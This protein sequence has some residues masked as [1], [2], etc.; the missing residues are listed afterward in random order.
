MSEKKKVK[1]RMGI[2]NKVTQDRWQ[3]IKDD[4]NIGLPISKIASRNSVSE[5]TVRRVRRSKN[6]YEYRLNNDRLLRRSIAVIEPT[7]GVAYEDYGPRR[8]FFSPKKVKSKNIEFCNSFARE[9]VQTA[10]CFGVV[11]LGAIVVIVLALVIVFIFS[12]VGGK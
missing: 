11:L 12:L 8:L 3:A 1:L 7:S 9:A 5:T 2:H 6:F 10:G 4:C